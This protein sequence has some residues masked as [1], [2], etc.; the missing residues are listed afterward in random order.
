M[1]DG[2]LRL[3]QRPPNDLE[4]SSGNGKDHGGCGKG[5]TTRYGVVVGTPKKFE[6]RFLPLR[7]LKN[8]PTL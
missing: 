4:G 8:R 2:Q 3:S 5:Q 1:R 7:S 6:R